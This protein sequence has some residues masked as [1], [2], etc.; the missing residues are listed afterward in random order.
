MRLKHIHRWPSMTM[1]GRIE[2]GDSHRMLTFS[3]ADLCDGAQ[4]GTNS[5]V[6]RRVSVL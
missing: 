3:Q 2:E 4:L 6:G 5:A 1:L